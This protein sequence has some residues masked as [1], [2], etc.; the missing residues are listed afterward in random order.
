MLWDIET[1]PPSVIH[2]VTE[3]RMDNVL[4]HCN[5]PFKVLQNL[6]TICTNG[7]VIKI[8]VP[9]YNSV[10]A[11]GDLTHRSFFGFTSFDCLNEYGDK[12]FKIVSI[13]TENG[14]L[15]RFFPKVLKRLMSYY[16]GNVI[17]A[18]NIE[19]EVIK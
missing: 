3:V 19:L 16:V 14:F 5:N 15:G 18:L 17:R 12:K 8:R 13:T 11:A 1:D 6:H 10:T 7:A 2:D 9:Y 4:E